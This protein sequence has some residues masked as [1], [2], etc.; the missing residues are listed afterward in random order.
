MSNIRVFDP[1]C[2]SG[3]FLVIA[4]KEMRAIE[5]K[6]NRRRGEAQRKSEIPLTNFRGIELRD[7]S[8]E[9]ARLA[10]IIAEY[11]AN[12][13]HIGQK[14]AR[15]A[16]LPLDTQNWVTCGNALRL[17][18]LSLCPPTGS[19][20]Q[21]QSDDLFGTPFVQA[22]I[23][24][25]NAGGETYI[26]G[27]PPYMGSKWQNASQKSELADIFDGR[28][29]GWKS[30][31]YVA[32]W[33]MKAVDY[34]DHTPTAA[35]FVATNSIAQGQQVP[36]FWTAVY[37]TG[38]FIN[39]AHTSF[40]W[41]NLATHNAS[42][43]VVIIGITKQPRARRIIYSAG[44]SDQDIVSEVAN[45]NPYLI[46]GSDLVVHP[47]TRNISDL[48]EMAR[49]NSPTDGGH[50]LLEHAELLSLNLMPSEMKFIRKFVGSKELI[51]GNSRLCIWIE[52]EDIDEADA[53]PAI[54]ERME[55]VRNFRLKSKK[56]GTQR[57]A[58]WPHR[59]DERKSIPTYP[60][61]C[62]PVISSENR[63][64]LPADLLPSGTIISNKAFGL[65]AEEIWPLAVICSRLNL[66]WVA[67]VCARM[68]TS[69]SYTNTLGW[70]TLPVPKLTANNK[71]NLTHCAKSILLAR[72][73][74]FPASIADLYRPDQM[75]DDLRAAHNHNDETLE[76]IYIGRRFKNDTERLEKLFEMYT[77]MTTNVSV[78]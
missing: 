71:T 15:H 31:D 39:F 47:S 68:G 61:I 3:N 10:L 40:K 25:E 66:A 70:N 29:P 24:F 9:I 78:Q 76:R 67:T 5:A 65:Q 49:G 32:G 54:K 50:L 6:I 27:N 17:D 13:I 77:K 34:A 72:E 55:L 56:L 19:S 4:Y 7:F 45:I 30:L 73:A 1:A 33:F 8:A 74:H 58:D 43:I 14:E 75:P 20:V 12:V 35:A 57:A 60:V 22:E 51:S 48:P 69:Y 16:F 52:D 11:Q 21:S 64:Y 63:P 26:C 2:G 44:D 38:H 59:F 42:V 37:R 28:V 46:P 23:D 62:V 18:W 41:S 53:I 36:I